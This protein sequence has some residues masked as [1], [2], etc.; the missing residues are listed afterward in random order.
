ML[1]SISRSQQGECHAI[2]LAPSLEGWS[3]WRQKVG[4]G[5]R[6]RSGAMGPR[7]ADIEGQFADELC[8]GSGRA[9]DS[10]GESPDGRFSDPRIVPQ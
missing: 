10:C 8:S 7:V 6:A 1:R 4:G 3:S 9:A 2:P 5:A